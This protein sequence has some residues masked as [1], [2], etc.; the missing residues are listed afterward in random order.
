MKNFWNFFFKGSYHWAEASTGL[1]DKKW[2]ARVICCFFLPGY[3]PSSEQVE[4]LAL[5][6]QEKH[7]LAPVTGA[8][9]VEHVEL[10]V[11]WW[12]N[13]CYRWRNRLLNHRITFNTPKL[14]WYGQRHVYCNFVLSQS[15]PV[16]TS[17]KIVP[18]HLGFAI[19]DCLASD[20][21]EDM[22]PSLL[23]REIGD[24]I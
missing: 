22:A 1:D 5:Q 6:G 9:R 24:T 12:E 8:N 4:L 17:C 11:S 14:V 2:P 18:Q 23:P 7:F 19:E 13:K 16:P 21:Y 20:I 15:I 10:A 3:C